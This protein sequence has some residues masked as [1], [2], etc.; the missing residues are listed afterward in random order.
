M[1]ENVENVCKTNGV[2][3][4]LYSFFL[5]FS[6]HFSSLTVTHSLVTLTTKGETKIE[7]KKK[8]AKFHF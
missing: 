3:S 6:G 5:I 4:I 1:L 7:N 8:K 2:L